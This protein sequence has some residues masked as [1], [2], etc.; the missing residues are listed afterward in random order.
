MLC[1]WQG[2][3]AQALSDRIANY[4]IQVELDTEQR[5]IFATT[6]LLWRNPSA[7]TVRDLQFHVYYNAFKNNQSTFIQESGGIKGQVGQA[8]LDE[9]GW[10]ATEV[11][12]IRD[13]YGNDL[14]SAQR[15]IQPDDDNTA[16]QSVL[17]VPLTTPVLPYDSIRVTLKWQAKIPK[18]LIRTG[19]NQDYY[20]M[21]QWFPKVGVYEP[22]GMRFAKKG[23]WNC[24][25][26]HR[27]TEYYSNFGVYKVKITTPEGY[28]IGASGERIEEIQKA[29]KQSV[30]YYVEDVIDFT[31]TAY[32]HFEEIWDKWQDVSL[33]LLRHPDRKCLTNRY[34]NAAKNALEYLDKYVGKYPYPTLTIV[35]PP[36]HGLRSSAMEYPTLVTGAGLYCFPKGIRTSESITVHE[37]VHQYFMQ[38]LATNEQEEAWMDEG[39]TSYYQ[40]RIIDHY[41]GYILE[42]PISG[43][44]A[45]DAA[46]R[47][48][49]F[50]NLD[51]PKID[52]A[53]KPGWEFKHGSYHSIVY[54]KAA[55]CL[56]T[57]DGLVGRQQMD[58]IMQT[59]FERWKFKHSCGQDFIDV[60]ND[61]TGEDMT[62]L[63]DQLIYGTEEC[64][65]AVT[66]IKNTI[67]EEKL[68]RFDDSEECLK[69]GKRGTFYKNEVII[70]RLGEVK[71]PVNLLLTFEDGST[72]TATWDGQARAK[73]FTYESPLKI[74]SA[75]IDP[76]F[77]LPIDKNQINNSLTLQA[78]STG[79]WRYVVNALLWVQELMESVTILV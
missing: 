24:H 14:T 13:Q 19:Y 36:Y 72:K 34:M 53:G 58:K 3:Q 73:T 22:A 8:F 52:F 57:L 15:Y 64:D 9:C 11:L 30:T 17:Q 78:D 44:K 71:L 55:L 10:A 26:Y 16:D 54:S 42:D 63:F 37:I 40:S 59:Y 23:Q 76:G 21:A 18:L 28:V 74:V 69:D 46:W 20:F 38:M 45:T 31:W 70:S 6:E 51:N 62:W 49:R 5:M 48:V 56:H 50:F 61:V 27:S 65:Y 33:R 66:A 39:F 77:K 32:P 29:G 67:P 25:Q 60:V 75:Q 79:V 4:D 7:D 41:N 68:G 1:T 12:D 35:D 47:R 2:I 43:F